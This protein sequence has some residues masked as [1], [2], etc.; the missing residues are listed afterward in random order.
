MV[1]ASRT[2][3]KP[4][5]ETQGEEFGRQLYDT[6]PHYIHVTNKRTT[7]N[8]LLSSRSPRVFPL[9]CGIF[10][11][12]NNIIAYSISCCLPVSSASAERALSKM[13]IIKN[14]HGSRKWLTAKYWQCWYYQAHGH[15]KPISR[16]STIALNQG[17]LRLAM[18]DNY[19][20]LHHSHF[21]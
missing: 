21:S 9:D 2:Q 10:S 8:K 4:R 3:I 18:E 1:D 20:T 15:Y 19:M 5:D 13:K 11:W 6:T 16:L 12:Q 7:N 14:R 17:N